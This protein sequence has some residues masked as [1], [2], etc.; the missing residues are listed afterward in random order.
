[1][2]ARM[3]K[4]NVSLRGQARRLRQQG[5]TYTEITQQLGSVPKG[6]LSGWFKD[7]RLT[8]SQQARIEGKIL[9]AGAQGR[10]LARAAWARKITAW[11][12]DIEDRVS[13]LAALPYDHL[14]IGKLV[15][16][17]M[18]LC[19]G[20]KYRS[21]RHKWRAR[22]LQYGNTAIQY[23]LQ[24]L[25]QLTVRACEIGGADGDRTRGLRNAIAALSQLS[26]CPIPPS[27]G[28]LR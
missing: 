5:F 17:I 2:F 15:C 18:Y 21:S 24:A 20:G 19:E 14:H 28:T 3:T 26:Y 25:G 16:S 13:P 1:M 7:L 12:K 10:P 22:V 9:A 6:T 4:T 8:A 27:E 11:Q 23:E